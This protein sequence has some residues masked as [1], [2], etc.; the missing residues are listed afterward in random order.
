MDQILLH[1]SNPSPQFTYPTWERRTDRIGVIFS[2]VCAIHCVATPFLLLA[3][4][5]FGKAWSHPASHWG[6][7]LVVIPIAAMM[8]SKG[9]ARHRRKWIMGIGSA[10]ILFVLAGAIAPY[11][12]GSSAGLPNTEGGALGTADPLN[13]GEASCVDA[14][15]PSLATT[16]DGKL[17]FHIPA[18]SIL[19]TL[20]GLL[21]IATH[22]TNLCRCSSCGKRKCS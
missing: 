16:E 12:D 14:C 11:V 21:L 6:M 2:I 17:G 9:Y 1:P 8:M 15:C 3:L 13:H 7:A 10:G 22:A 19:T 18:A 5:A 4:P 20:G